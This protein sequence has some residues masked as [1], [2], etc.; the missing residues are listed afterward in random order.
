MLY[1]YEF[2][3]CRK[4]VDGVYE[5]Q[6]LW[7]KEFKSGNAFTS[8]KN[9]ADGY[10]QY[11]KECFNIYNRNRGKENPDLHT[12]LNLRARFG[13]TLKYKQELIKQ[14]NGL[15]YLC[16]EVLPDDRRNICVEHDKE[17]GKIYGVAC[18]GCNIGIAGFNHDPDR[19]ERVA[20]N[21]RLRRK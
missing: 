11:C 1:E 6:C 21:I 2:A 13:I 8:S 9:N 15:C 3:T 10:A 20:R 16:D 14:Q 19:M 18:R 5:K 17:T 7:C 12:K 4:T